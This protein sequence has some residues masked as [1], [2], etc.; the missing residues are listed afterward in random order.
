MQAA[1]GRPKGAVFGLCSARLPLRPLWL[2]EREAAAFTAWYTPGTHYLT[3]PT[4]SPFI[5]D[6]RAGRE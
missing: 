3:P 5:P 2:A 4:G 6:P 1:A